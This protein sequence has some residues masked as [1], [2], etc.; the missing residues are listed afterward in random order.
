MD[1]AGCART[2]SKN[3]EDILHIYK[4]PTLP[5]VSV[6]HLCCLP[7][8]TFSGTSEAFNTSCVASTFHAHAHNTG[9]TNE[10]NLLKLLYAVCTFDV[11]MLVGDTC[12]QS[13]Y[14]ENTTQTTAFKGRNAETRSDSVADRIAHLSSG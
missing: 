4:C 10:S 5:D 12:K 8:A 9:N 2:F 3:H 7:D 1:R 14:S 13:C 11:W 6:A